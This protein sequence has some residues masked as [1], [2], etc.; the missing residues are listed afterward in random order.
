M[1]IAIRCEGCGGKY[2]VEKGLWKYCILDEGTACKVH[3]GQDHA[4]LMGSCKPSAWLQHDMHGESVWKWRERCQ[5]TQG[6]SVRPQRVLE[7]HTTDVCLISFG[8][9]MGREILKD[10]K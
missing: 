2:Q 6:T 7:W 8:Y 5:S 1:T 9:E 10:F 3:R 4:A